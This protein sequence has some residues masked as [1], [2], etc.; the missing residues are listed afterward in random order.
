M[1]KGNN[2]SSEKYIMNVLI[3]GSTYLAPGGWKPIYRGL[4]NG[5]YY[6]YKNNTS[7]VYNY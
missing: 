6:Q 7:L 3:R 4:L 1:F 5:L 2:W